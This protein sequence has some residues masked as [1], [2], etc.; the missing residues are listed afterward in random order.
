MGDRRQIEN[1]GNGTF[2]TPTRK[3]R[4]SIRE[5]CYKPAMPPLMCFV[6]SYSRYSSDDLLLYLAR[7]ICFSIL[8][9]VYTTTMNSKWTTI[10]K[11]RITY[12]IDIASLAHVILQ[13]LPGCVKAQITNKDRRTFHRRRSTR[14]RRVGSSRAFVTSSVIILVAVVTFDHDEERQKVELLA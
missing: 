4:I 13:I 5:Q 12:T 10:D 2:S 14:R 7:F 11:T 1:L 3:E 8:D 6:R 9:L